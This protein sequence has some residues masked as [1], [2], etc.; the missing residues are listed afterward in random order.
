MNNSSEAR[1]AVAGRRKFCVV[2]QPISHS[3]S[4]QIHQA[5]GEQLG[6]PLS[7]E[8]L[9]VAPGNLREAIKAFRARNGR[10]LN[11]TIP[12]KEEAFAL[13]DEKTAR[14]GAAGAANTLWFTDD[15]RTVAD[16]TDGAGLVRD[17]EVNHGFLLSSKR[18][19]VLGAGGAARG[20]IPALLERNPLGLWVSNRTMSRAKELQD[21]FAAQSA[22][23]VCPWGQLPEIFPDL[24]VNAT[25]LS[26]SGGV[27]GLCLPTDCDALTC[28]DMA[29]ADVDT[30]F[31]SWAKSAGVVRAFDGLGMLVEQA[32]EA[33]YQWHG[34]R[35]ETQ[36]IIAALRSERHGGAL[37]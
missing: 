25:S 14:A 33:F 21:F 8:R 12:L 28:Y 10:G 1:E 4:P 6:I 15:G 24:I 37:Q 34:R 23:Q 35:P 26:L 31:V 29:Y 32:A 2:G 13:A 16:N 27:P 18:V 22:L 7:Y 9:E 20:V 30:A 11:V 19:L 17:L 5:F 36:T 3:K